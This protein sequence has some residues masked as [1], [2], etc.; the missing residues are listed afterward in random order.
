M[1]ICHG[2]NPPPTGQSYRVRGLVTFEW[3]LG[4]KVVRTASKHSAARKAPVRNADP[5]GFSAA[6]CMVVAP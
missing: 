5:K 6:E 2:Q 4:K 1:P 3:R